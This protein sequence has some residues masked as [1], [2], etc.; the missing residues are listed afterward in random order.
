MLSNLIRLPVGQMSLEDM[1]WVQARCPSEL[2]LNRR[3]R[4]AKLGVK[5][6]SSLIEISDAELSWLKFLQA[7]ID[8]RRRFDIEVEDTPKRIDA[9]E[10]DIEIEA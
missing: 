10:F 2:E 1:A 3:S 7:L 9:G 6:P 4:L 5:L 8:L